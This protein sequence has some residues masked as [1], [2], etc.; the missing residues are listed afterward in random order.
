LNK[1]FGLLKATEKLDDA[2]AVEETIKEIW[3]AHPSQCLRN[4]LDNGITDVL[5]GKGKE[6]LDIFKDL[7]VKDEHYAEAW[8]KIAACE[9]MLGNMQA[10]LDAAEKALNLMPTHFQAHNGVG[11]CRFD[12]GQHDLAAEAFKKSID[13]DPWS[14]VA[15]KLAACVDLLQKG[16]EGKDSN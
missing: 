1:L 8:N 9:Y 3:K 15:S 16:D 5:R 13:L 2:I 11:L 14:P 7:A 4:Q 6:A 10:S 12:E